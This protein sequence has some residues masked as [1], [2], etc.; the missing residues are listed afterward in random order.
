[1][2][3]EFL[4]QLI[5]GVLIAILYFEFTK[6]KDTNFK[7]IMLFTSFYISMIF[8]AKLSDID[9][10]IITSAFLSKTVFTLVDERIRHT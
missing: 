6:P 3:S 10:N 9:P 5:K 8:G 4:Q 2:K 1:M 7:N